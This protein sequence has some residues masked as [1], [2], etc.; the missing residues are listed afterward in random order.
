M[1]LPQA[2]RIR[3]D[4]SKIT[5]YLLNLSHPDGAGKARFF[6]RFGFSV[7]DPDVL[8]NALRKHGSDNA[9]SRMVE[10][11]FGWRYT[12]DG[13]LETPD[14]RNPMIR[15]VWIMEEEG[16]APRLITAYPV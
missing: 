10:T 12:V 8:V 15:T 7:N 1:N 2:D 9:V 4:R 5:E 13:V 6:F 11:H 3:V 14:G 16:D